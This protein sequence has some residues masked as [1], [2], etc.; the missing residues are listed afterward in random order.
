V[1]A[2]PR[3]PESVRQLTALG[4]TLLQALAYTGGSARAGDFR[5]GASSDDADRRGVLGPVRL[6]MTVG[7]GLPNVFSVTGLFK[8]TPYFGGGVN[9]GLIPTI[10]VSY[11]G[12]ATI[13]YQ[14]FDVF[15]RVYPFGGGL[16]LGIG[17]GYENVRGTL[18]NTLDTS[19]FA[20]WIPPNIQVPNP[21]AYDSAGSLRSLILTPQIGYLHTTD[22]GFSFGID[23]GAQIPVAPSDVSFNTRLTMPADTPQQ[24]RDQVRSQLVEPNDEKVRDTLETIGRTPIPTV[25]LRVGW[26][27]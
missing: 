7:V 3:A 12:E 6:G 21:I 14:E 20:A 1:V 24:V 19:A 22:I 10:R 27:F 4:S 26:L 2:A 5:A 16:F 23:V 9:F 8:I 17:M 18:S 25:N 11:Y 13:R 15:A